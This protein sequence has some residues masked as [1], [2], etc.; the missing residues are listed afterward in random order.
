MTHTLVVNGLGFVI[1]LIFGV[2]AQRSGFCLTSALRNWWQ[3]GDGARI[4]MFALTVAVAIAGSQILDAAGLVNL[5]RSLHL[6]PSFPWLALLIGGTLFGYG[7]VLANGCGARALVLLG[8]GNLRSFVVLLCIGISGYAALSGVA[9]PIADW[10]RQLATV[11]ASSAAVPVLLARAAG[12]DDIATRWIAIVLLVGGLTAFALADGKLRAAPRLIV[13]ALV[14]G[15]LVPAA[16]FTT[17]Y[18]GAD[19][20]EPVPL[21]ALSFIGPIGETIQYLMLASG[22]A[23]SFSVM[24]VA[25]VP[26]GSA[27]AAAVAGD[28]ELRTFSSPQHMLRLMTGGV[29][30]GLGG[31]MA[32]G[33]SIGQG[34]SGLSTLAMASLAASAGILLGAFLAIRAPLQQWRV[35]RREPQGRSP[36]QEAKHNGREAAPPP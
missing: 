25:G 8:T 7:M 6:Q 26:A 17:G 2:V 34:L 19:D 13:A 22:T 28:F 35:R 20:F 24:L 9:V 14:I 16:W 21:V 31:A 10:L 18:L 36:W 29:L 15:F 33:C 11:S 12:S 4:R 3:D 1:G 5:G 32:R 27:F 30:M 23:L